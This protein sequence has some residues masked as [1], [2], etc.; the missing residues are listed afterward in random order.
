MTL[1]NKFIN[2][3]GGQKSEISLTGVKLRYQ[4]GW[5]LPEAL[6]AKICSLVFFCFKRLSSFL[7]FWLLPSS[8]LAVQHSF[9]TSYLSFLC[10]G[11]LIYETDKS[12]VSIKMK[13]IHLRHLEQ[14]LV[15][16]NQSVFCRLS[17]I[18]TQQAV[19]W[20]FLKLT[21]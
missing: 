7:G 14:C 15:F 19:V 21:N 2:S 5:F 20:S 18:G 11:F 3:S 16:S 10:L 17:L 12:W 9:S 1:K 6:M 4:Q 13:C 8:K